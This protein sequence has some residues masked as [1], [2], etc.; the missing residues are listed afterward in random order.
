MQRDGGKE[1]GLLMELPH[2]SASAG[3]HGF[4]PW[5]RRKGLRRDGTRDHLADVSPLAVHAPWRSR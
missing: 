1:P 4:Y 2:P 3:D 5:G